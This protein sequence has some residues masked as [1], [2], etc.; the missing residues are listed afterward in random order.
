[1]TPRIPLLVAS[2]VALLALTA[3]GRAASPTTPAAAP[4]PAPV[5]ASAAAPTSAA[6]VPEPSASKP[7]KPA[8]AKPRTKGDR[9]K[10]DRT[11]GEGCPVRAAALQKVVKLSAGWR[12]QAS[13]IEC[14]HGW[15]QA[16]VTAPTPEQ[17]GDGVVLFKYDAAAGT[18]VDKGQGSSVDCGAFGI[19]EKAGRNLSVCFYES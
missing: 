3:C 6:A 2:G 13:S 7:T 12:I 11:G 1:M 16:A 14:S 8:A 10:G 19:P 4:A 17:Q 5:S 18:W 9:T 15:A